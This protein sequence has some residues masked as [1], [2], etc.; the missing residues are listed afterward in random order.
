[1]EDIIFGV[2]IS[3]ISLYTCIVVAN[4]AARIPYFSFLDERRNRAGSIDGL[5]GYLALLVFFHH[6]V[7][8]YYWK[9]LQ[10]WERPPEDL[11]QNFGK[12][13]VAIFFMITG[14]LF[15]TKINNSRGSLNWLALY[16]SRFFRIVPLYLAAF[17]IVLIFVFEATGYEL[18]TSI[19]QLFKDLTKWGLF[20]GGFINDFGDTKRIIAGVDWTLK[21]EWLFYLLLPRER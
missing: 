8:T 14:F 18:H 5:R 19:G 9:S 15:F 6:F 10:V 12:V 2:S 11:Y 13:G 16:S 1:M 3:I 4:R 20:I 17:F 7:V 21:Y